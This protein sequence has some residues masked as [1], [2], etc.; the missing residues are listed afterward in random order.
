MNKPYRRALGSAIACLSFM[1][2]LCLADPAPAVQKVLPSAKCIK[3]EYPSRSLTEQEEGTVTL[4][5][6]IS[7]TGEVIDSRIERTS[8]YRRLDE[9]ARTAIA[10]C[11]F[12][13]KQEDG[14]AV[15]SWQTVKYVWK[16][17]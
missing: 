11:E 6:L 12:H 13:A 16:L 9:R 3:P 2:G 7:V 5:F 10:K 14:K 17:D 8:G 15:Q 4:G 1:G